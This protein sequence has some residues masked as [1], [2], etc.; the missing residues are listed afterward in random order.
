MSS[1]RISTAP[2]YQLKVTLKDSSPRIWRRILVSGDASLAKLHRILQVAM[3]WSN[4]H[5]HLFMI[6]R[7]QYSAPDEERELD[8]ADE[9]KV[10]LTDLLGPKDRFIY[11]YDF[12][13]GW[14]H[15]ILVEKIVPREEGTRYPVCAAGARAC[16]PEDCGGIGDTS[17]SWRRSRTRSTRNMKCCWN[18]SGAGLIPRHSIWITLTRR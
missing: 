3:G 12:G 2:V 9:R 11:E 4:S 15:E 18:G 6:H 7:K 1:R 16:P 8:F 5:L 14:L 10:K 17:T 13:D